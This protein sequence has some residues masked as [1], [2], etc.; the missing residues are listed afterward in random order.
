MIKKKQIVMT[1]LLSLV[2]LCGCGRTAAGGI[3]S[4]GQTSVKDGKDGTNGKDGADGKDGKDGQAFLNG[5]GEP[6]STLGNDGDS[7]IDTK[8]YDLYTKKNGVW[9]KEGSLKGNNGENGTNGK[10]GKDG[11]NGEDGHTPVITIGENGNWY[12][13]GVDTGKK[14]TTDSQEYIVTYDLD[15]GAM[16][17]GILSATRVKYGECIIDLP[18]P[19]KE[20]F[21]FEGWY[22]NEGENEGKF[23]ATT[24]VTKDITLKAKWK[25]IYSQ[26]FTVSWL[27]YDGTLLAT[28]S[29][30]YGSVPSYTGE[31]PTKASDG[32]YDYTF[33]SWSPSVQ[34]IYQDTSYVAQF[35]K[36][37]KTIKVTF[38]LNGKG[39]INADGFTNNVYTASYGSVLSIRN[40]KIEYNESAGTDFISSWYTDASLTTPASFPMIIKNDMTIYPKWEDQKNMFS[41]TYDS[42][43]QGY[44]LKSFKN[45]TSSTIQQV[46]IPSTY[47]DGTNGEHP[48]IAMRDTFRN[49]TNINKVILPDSIKTIAEGAF[50]N[51]SVTSVTLPGT[52]EKIPASCFKDS[53]L[54]EITIPDTVT[55]LGAYAFYG[56]KLEEVVLPDNITEIPEYC[57]ARNTSNWYERRLKN[58]TF[59]NKLKKISAF[60]F[61]ECTNLTSINLPDTLEEISQYAFSNCRNI[62][63]LELPTNLK[64]IGWYAF[65]YC[66]NLSIVKFKQKLET[67]YYSAFSY[68]SKLESIIL[69]S[70]ITSLGDGV[71]YN[72][73][74]LTIY[75]EAESVPTGWNS[76]FVGS[77]PIVYLLSETDPGT[78]EG[79]Y[80]H[81]VNGLPEKW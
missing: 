61:N 77:G 73:S 16:P 14:A 47:N 6:A 7:Y 63:A 54:S 55:E 20:N 59:P 23:T 35:T 32:E 70:T 64:S 25:S 72:D 71:F 28:D 43:N 10:D 36:K 49:V 13:D 11:E 48:V 78:K 19:T 46:T 67:I 62:T 56:T 74:I 15:G 79:N 44:I 57:F 2:L 76:N 81:Y 31:T 75:V 58:I 41:Y 38:D 33:S 27:N 26:V 60:A 12:V 80:W 8:T 45:T 30:N 52:L 24:P 4:A 21:I 3:G 65:S 18:T 34:A 51:S 29:V 69:P 42:E 17:E 53:S 22:L 39:T 5:E 40:F 50:A 37:A 66:T 9:V 68:C 1:S